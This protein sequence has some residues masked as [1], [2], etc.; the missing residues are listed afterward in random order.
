MYNRKV[1]QAFIF[2]TSNL[3]TGYFEVMFFSRSSP[4]VTRAIAWHVMPG[5]GWQRGER[6][7]GAHSWHIIVTAELLGAPPVVRWRWPGTR[8]GS[9]QW[10]TSE[11]L[12]DVTRRSFDR[13]NYQ[14]FRSKQMSGRCVLTDPLRGSSS[15]PSSWWRWWGRRI[16]CEWVTG[17]CRLTDWPGGV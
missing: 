1:F 14:K 4:N 10:C 6:E 16:R 12:D 11:M 2:H 17:K 5:T 9:L 7:G 15:S 3:V 13:W 8:S